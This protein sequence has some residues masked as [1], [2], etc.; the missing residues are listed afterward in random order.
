VT[1]AKLR[2]ADA[3][4]E[5]LCMDTILTEDV[6]APPEWLAGK[7]S[8]TDEGCWY[9]LGGVTTNGYAQGLQRGEDAHRTVYRRLVGPI[10]RGLVIDHACHGRALCSGGRCRHRRCVN[11]AHLLPRSSGSNVAASVNSIQVTRRLRRVCGRGHPYDSTNVR[12]E[13][14]GAATIRHCRTCR[15]ESSQR[16]RSAP[17][18]LELPA[19]PA[20]RSSG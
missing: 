14:R 11:W 15:R 18:S 5:P 6:N 2:S 7:I 12:W 20:E 8:I 17:T 16:R 3:T 1:P 19:P 10:A 4:A 13:I 9:W